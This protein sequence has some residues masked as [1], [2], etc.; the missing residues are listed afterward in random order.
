MSKNSSHI[1]ILSTEK[2]NYTYIYIDVERWVN[3][4]IVLFLIFLLLITSF[5]LTAQG[6]IKI[7]P[8]K[9]NVEIN[10]WYE[11][12]EEIKALI[13]ITN[14]YSYGVNVTSKIE[15][16]GP[17]VITKR[18]SPIPDISWVTIFPE[19][20]YLSPKTTRELEVSINISEDQQ[21]LNYNKRWETGVVISSNIPLGSAS[22]MNFE[23]EI[24]VKLYIITP[25]GEV[26]K[27]QYFYILLFFIFLSIIIYISSSFVKKKKEKLRTLYYF[28]NKK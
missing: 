25:D 4:T 10:E 1:H 5:S 7:W 27:S 28:K 14:P 2:I 16:P 17:K 23:L 13:Y 21:E 15:N 26:E 19:R 8:G 18:Y 24:A 9:I 6:G 11:E 3:K 22:G 12:G 20:F